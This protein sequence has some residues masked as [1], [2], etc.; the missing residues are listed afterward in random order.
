MSHTTT[1]NLPS[2]PPLSPDQPIDMAEITKYYLS[3][4]HSTRRSAQFLL[5]H[6]IPITH[7]YAIIARYL[8]CMRLLHQE[9]VR[10]VR[11]GCRDKSR[12]NMAAGNKERQNDPKVLRAACELGYFVHR[13]P[14]QEYVGQG[15]LA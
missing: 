8:S 7:V 11:Y 6:H 1:P 9:H 12:A 15:Y 14:E 2:D 5:D 4:D 10:M 3:T 13:I